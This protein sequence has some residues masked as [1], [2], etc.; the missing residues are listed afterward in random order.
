MPHVAASSENGLTCPTECIPDRLAVEG[1][2]KGSALTCGLRGN[3]HFPCRRRIYGINS[4]S[5]SI[6]APRQRRGGRRVRLFRAN[7]QVRSVGDNTPPLVTSSER[8]NPP[9]LDILSSPLPFTNQCHRNSLPAARCPPPSSPSNRAPTRAL[10]LRPT[11]NRCGMA[12]SAPSRRV[13]WAA[14]GTSL[15]YLPAASSRTSRVMAA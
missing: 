15:L 6:L 7:R 14:S 8:T 11:P 13:T 1:R 4:S 9:S 10:C 3:P 2:R 12:A 5:L